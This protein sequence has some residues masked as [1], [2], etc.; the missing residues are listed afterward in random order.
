M[1]WSCL[2]VLFA[3]T[4]GVVL[5]A[6]NAPAIEPA[7]PTG[8]NAPMVKPPAHVLQTRI[9]ADRGEFD[10][11]G[12]QVTYHGHV[13]VDDPEM[14]LTGEWLITDLPQAG[15]HVNHIVAETNVVIDFVD[16]KG[17]TNHATCDRTVYSYEV[18]DGTTNELIML[19]GHAKVENAEFVMIGEP[20]TLNLTTRKITADNPVVTP[21]Q[22]LVNPTA[23]ANSPTAV[24]PLATDTNF[25]PGKPDLVPQRDL[26]PGKF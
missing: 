22:S 1:K 12:R 3:V 9:S 25:P 21:R 19:S 8:P 20:I 6:Q 16:D 14:K 23:G 5:P 11:A 24:K 26:I 15:E 7:A 10:M 4:G 13:R 18:K 2:V 17:Q